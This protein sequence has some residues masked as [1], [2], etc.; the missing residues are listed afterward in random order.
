MSEEKKTYTFTGKVGT[1]N[2]TGGL[3]NSASSGTMGHE[4]TFSSYP[5]IDNTPI[6]IT[7]TMNLAEYK[8]TRWDKLR[9]RFF[10]TVHPITKYRLRLVNTDYEGWD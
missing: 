3:F 1:F 7:W 5:V 6:N 2:N 8:P 10:K 9:D 4:A